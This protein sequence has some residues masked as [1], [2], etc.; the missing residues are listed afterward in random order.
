MRFALSLL[1]DSTAFFAKYFSLV[2]GDAGI[3]IV[4]RLNYRRR[5]R[6]KERERGKHSAFG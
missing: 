2:V 5:Y 1:V 4:H 3:T 6:H